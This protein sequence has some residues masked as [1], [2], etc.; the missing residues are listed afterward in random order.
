[1]KADPKATISLNVSFDIDLEYDPFKGR[2]VEQF[3]GLFEDD[4]IDALNE[5]RP[6]I[7]EV[8]HLHTKTIK[9]V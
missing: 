8:Y 9:D 3:V 4:L 2:S 1:M 6:E 5:L 7:Q